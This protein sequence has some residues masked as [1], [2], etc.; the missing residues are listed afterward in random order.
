MLET[1]FAGRIGSAPGVAARCALLLRC[2][3]LV[4]ALVVPLSA[5]A[6]ERHRLACPSEAPAEWGLPKPAPLEQPAVLS[7]P[8]GEPIDASAPPSLVPDRM[9]ARGSAWHNV[10][11]MGDEPGWSH[12]V[13]CQYRGS[14]RVLR[15]KADGLKQCEQTAAPYSAKGGIAP[16]AVQTMACD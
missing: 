10:W 15:L 13:D 3:P 11:L 4:A 7:Q 9:Y 6:Q 12:F 8:N 16:H 1:I 14:K 2:V 5:Q